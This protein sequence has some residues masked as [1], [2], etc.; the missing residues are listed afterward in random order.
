MT[1]TAVFDLDGT[2]IDSMLDIASAVNRMR[3]SFG[4]PVMAPEEIAPLTGDGVVMLVTRALKGSDVSVEEGVRRQS[5]FYAE[6]PVETTV[7]YPGVREGLE[8]MKSKGIHLAVVTNKQ[9]PIARKI[10]ETLGAASFFDEI[11]GGGSGFPLKPD[12]AALLAF[13]K[14]CGAAKENCWMLGDHYTDLGAGRAAGFNRGFARWGYG[15]LRTETFDR[16]FDSF[17]AFTAAVTEVKE[18][19]RSYGTLGK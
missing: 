10:L 16:E 1:E 13:Q 17:E 11:W 12:P 3:E 6:N 14:Q 2:L 4:L 15:E 18:G 9:T 19:S 8:I 5:F 7:L